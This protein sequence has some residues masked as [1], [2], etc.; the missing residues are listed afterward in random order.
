MKYLEIDA[1]PGLKL[2]QALEMIV[3]GE[4]KT[5]PFRGIILHIGTNNL[6]ETRYKIMSKTR[7]ILRHLQN[8]VPL[9]KLAVSMIIPRP[10]DE[11]NA[12]EANRMEVN[13]MLKWLCKTMHVTFLNTFRAVS[14]KGVLD[15]SYY[16]EDLKHLKGAGIMSMKE[17]FRG[18]TAVLM[19]Q[20]QPP[21]NPKNH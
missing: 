11:G 12:I 1:F 2:E 17:F 20:T 16:A 6:K 18:A 21:Q 13:N 19:D 8:S 9:T 15:R 5:S 3:S 7:D 14:H 4:I 10:C